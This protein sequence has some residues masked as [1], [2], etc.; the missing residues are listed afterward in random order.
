[1]TSSRQIFGHPAGLFV[2]F[3]TEMWERLSYYGM[4]GIF[5][6]YLTQV[7]VAAAMGWSSLSPAE[8]ESN[9]LEY[10]GWYLMCVYLTPV[11]GGYLADQYLGQRRAIMI[12]GF[13]M[14]I[15]KFCLAVPFGWIV[16]FEKLFL[17]LGLVLSVLGNGFFKPNISSLVGDLYDKK[18]TRRDSAFTIF[19]MGI[20]LGALLG[21]LLIGYIGEKHD[22][23]WAFFATGVGMGIG[24]L[25]QY[26]YAPR[27]LGTIGIVPKKLTQNQ[28]NILKISDIT[29]AERS[30]M[31]AILIFSALSMIFWAGFEQTSGAFMLFAKNNTDL[32]ILGY[33]IPASWLQSVNPLFIFLFA[34]V[35]SSIWL[36]MGERQPS[37]PMKYS[38]GFILLG[39]AFL[40]PAFGALA[41][42]DNPEVK[43]HILWLTMA[44]IFMTF[45]EL[46]ISPVGLSLVT[47]LSPVRYVGFMMGIWFLFA[48]LGNKI[49]AEIGQ[50]MTV[51]GYW[52]S[53]ISTAIFSFIV[54]GLIIVL[55]N[56]ILN[57][58]IENK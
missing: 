31:L 36:K 58:M 50:F 25:I 8:L 42:D 43:V 14:M 54:A 12:G 23:Q 46:C 17:I 13:L 37:A 27:Y 56:Y 11:I 55:R 51:T 6:L 15:G 40:F 44:F 47:K 19:Y 39:I 32:V 53:F 16:G 2:L 33:E 29:P 28:E 22:Y 45:A 26:F 1:M 9:A 4:R 52:Q 34:P 5:V 38:I 7:F 49:S 30:K 57:F 35:A 18:D 20:N 3:T 24:L 48:G 10:L 21:F 41:L